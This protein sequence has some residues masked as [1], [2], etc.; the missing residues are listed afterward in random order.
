MLKVNESAPIRLANAQSQ[1]RRRYCSVYCS[2]PI[3]YR[4]QK[5]NAIASTI[6]ARSTE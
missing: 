1:L 3:A 4:R 2:Q 6:P 5:F